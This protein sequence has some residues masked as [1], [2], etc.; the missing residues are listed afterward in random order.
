MRRTIYEVVWLLAAFFVIVCIW[1]LG[2]MVIG[3]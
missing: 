2:G 1:N 3:C